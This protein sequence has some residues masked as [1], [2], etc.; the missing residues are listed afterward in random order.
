M[1]FGPQLTLEFL[2]R[3]FKALLLLMASLCPTLAIWYVITFTSDPIPQ[4]ENHLFHEIAIA[5]ATV[6]ASFISYVSW[7]SYQ[8]SGEIFLR[9]MTVGFL[10]FTLVYATHGLLT[11]AAHHNLA[12]FLLYGPASRLAM[13]GCM[14]YGLAHYGKPAEPPDAVWRTGFWRTALVVIAVIVIAVAGLAHS[15]VAA[16]PWLRKTLEIGAAALALTALGAMAGRRISSP[17]MMFFAVG[18]LLFVQ[19][20]GAFLLAR[21]WDH[22]WWLAHA[23]FAAGFSVVSWGV[24]QA[25]LTTKSFAQAYSQEHLMRALEREQAH[26]QSV[27]DA[28][29]DT[30]VITDSL[31]T[32][33]MVNRQ[34]TPLLGFSADEL[35]GQSVDVLVPERLRANHPAQRNDFLGA[36]GSRPMGQGLE[37]R[38]RR[39]D[40]AEIPVEVSLSEI[41]AG[42]SVLVASA[43]RDVTDRRRM[44]EELRQ[45]AFNDPL[46][47]LP[48][49]RLFQDR[50]KQALKI[51][52][53]QNSHGALLFLDLNRFKQLNDTHGHDVG[54]QLLMEVADRLRQTVRATDT[55][56]RL[57][58]DEFVVLLEN[59]AAD[60]TIA[61][62]YAAQTAEKI[63]QA[64][65]EDYVFGD[66]RHRGSASIGI[67]VF[68]GDEG[69]PDQIIKDADNA[70]Y[71]AKKDMVS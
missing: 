3:L 25:L 10:A 14:A 36:S 6:E 49:R 68:L 20:A 57:G 47:R 48:N 27:F 64:L 56:A 37:V 50:L 67:S 38:A 12:L 33:T 62:K 30:L 58:G 35:I 52:R 15:P 53:R 46:T 39:K 7:R 2:T 28:S 60:S 26:L 54:D 45:M 41:R 51:S 66:I 31:G 44:E 17:L 63:H 40:G 18:L 55:V 16:S 71:Q 24:A 22:L 5:I 1:V 42:N 59:L 11:P 70:M 21:P 8:A 69:D 23:I 61:G 43:M 4:F 29:P 13:L 65:A 9:W 19:A 34:V 32:I